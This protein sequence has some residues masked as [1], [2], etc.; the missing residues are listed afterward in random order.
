[1]TTVRNDTPSTQT[2]E[3]LIF[4]AGE[5]RDISVELSP[6]EIFDA[7]VEPLGKSLA[8]ALDDGDF[9]L[10]GA[11]LP[12]GMTPGMAVT[13]ATVQTVQE[14][15]LPDAPSDGQIFGRQDGAWVPAGGPGGGAYYFRGEVAN[16]AGLGAFTDPQ[17]EEYAAVQDTG[18]LWQYDGAAW[19]DTGINASFQDWIPPVGPSPLPINQGTITPDL[20]FSFNV[21]FQGSTGAVYRIGPTNSGYNYAGF[22]SENV[23]SQAGDYFEF[24]SVFFNTIQGLGLASTDTLTG[25]G[26]NEN[27]V[28]TPGEFCTPPSNMFSYTGRDVM[29]YVKNNG[30]YTTGAQNG[31]ALQMF[32]PS[33]AERDD[34]GAWSTGGK[35][36]L[37][38]DAQY[39]FY[40]AVYLPSSQVWKTLFRSTTPLPTQS[41][42][43]LWAG[44][45]AG[46]VLSQR[47]NQ[48]VTPPPPGGY[49]DLFYVKLDG[50]NE[51]VD[52]GSP[53][54]LSNALN[55]GQ[56][57]SYG[58]T[59]AN[60]WNPI[61][62]PTPKYTLLRN[63][64]NAFYLNPQPNPG[65]NS[66]PYLTAQG[67]QS[68]ANTWKQVNAGDRLVLQSNGTN[69][70]F[71][72]N[73]QTWWNTTIPATITAN[74]GPSGQLTVG[75]GG[76]ISSY[77]QGGIDNCWFMDRPLVGQEIAEAG[78]GGNPEDWSFYAEILAFYLM[79]E[80]GP[81]A[82]PS[83]TDLTGNQPDATLING[84]PT[85]FT[86]Y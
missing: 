50:F 85:D 38:L 37:G 20:S 35:V 34:S 17:E 71:M 59:V 83:I 48:V 62:A 11:A 3:G 45:Y 5:S 68:G 77:L 2:V 67:V 58:C 76:P 41:Y 1:M 57:F 30:L 69:I 4:T 72:V 28:A 78:N 19:A 79:G 49:S 54:G 22:A 21:A 9:S 31:G 15:T 29:G 27:G 24:P 65:G 80:G 18:T 70:Q 86:P 36:R 32:Q 75:E 42:R 16:Q 63:G 23:I 44:F 40:M 43:F 64:A 10:V 66:Q 53:A 39:H 52:L 84:E 8:T 46:S 51:Y 55:F 61:G 60:Q 14:D 82:F 33:A 56:P 74:N 47:P 81:V 26:P 25:N 6:S 7:Q 12:G 13:P 73:G